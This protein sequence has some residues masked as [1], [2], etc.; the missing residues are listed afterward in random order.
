VPEP[1]QEF[2]RKLLYSLVEVATI[3]GRPPG[4]IRRWI[5]RGQLECV[6]VDEESPF[7]PFDALVERLERL[8]WKRRRR[9][10]A[11]DGKSGSRA[12]DDAA[13]PPPA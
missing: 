3:T 7:V 13:T 6:I 8:A 5:H 1:A 11:R 4:L 10:L 2:E 12:V 9:T